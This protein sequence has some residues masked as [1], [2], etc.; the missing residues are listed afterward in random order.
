MHEFR[1]LLSGV[2]PGLL[3]GRWGFMELWDFDKHF[4]HNTFF[5]R[6]SMEGFVLDTLKAAF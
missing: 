5:P 6:T 2:Q 3:Y 4:I 1:R